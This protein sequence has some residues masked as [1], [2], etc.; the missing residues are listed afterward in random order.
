MTIIKYHWLNRT[1]SAL[2]LSLVLLTGGVALAQ[3]TRSAILGTVKDAT[4]AVV[5]GATVD[6]T[7]TDTNATAKLSTNSSGYFE[8]PYLLPGVY[9]I[10]VTAQGFKRYVQQGY[11]LS[12][13]SRQN[14][15]I[16]L[17]IGST[18]ESVTVTATAA[19]LETTSGSGTS[20]LEGRQISDLPV[21]GN[22]AMLLARSAPGM[23]WTAQPNY[24]SLHSNVGASSV[25]AAGG[26]G[27]SEFSLDGVPS[28][29]GG[30][31]T[32]YLPYTDTVAEFKVETAP[33]DASKGHT[34]S[35]T[36]SLSTKSGTND[37][38]GQLTW[39]HWQQRLNATQSTTNA[40]YW[41]RI[42]QAEAA[43]NTALAEQLKSQSPQPTGRSNNWAASAG[44]PVRAP[45]LY[46]GKDKLFFFFSYNGF[47]D[48]KTE[49]AT[50]VNRTVPSDAH[51]RGDFSDLLKIDPVRYQIYD[52]R[53][54]HC[55]DN[56]PGPCNR[57]GV[58][59]VRNPFPN[60]Q[61][62]ILNPMYK[63]YEALYPRANNVPGVVS[64][65][66]FNN[67]LA[68][69]TPFNWDYKAFTN[70]IDL[71]LTSKQR[72]FGK[73]SY[74]NFSPEN[75]GDWVYET[76]PGLL[77]NGLVRK[78]VGVT[79]DHVYTFNS[80]TIFNWSVAWNRFIEGSASNAVQT[81]F[82]PSAV[83]LPG[84]LDQKAG[85]FIHLPNLDFSAGS[86]SDFTR[87]YP[88][89]GRFS[90]GTVRG[91]LSKYIG[92]H[93][94]RFGVDLRENWRA[95]NGPGNSSGSFS[96]NNSFVRR[97]QNTTNAGVIG[98]EWAAFMLGAP[99]G[100]SISTNDDLYL[101]NKFYAGYV[102]DDWKLTSKLTVNLGLRY[103]LEGGFRERFNR[104]LAGFD[105]EAP[106]PI[107]QAAQEAYAKLPA[108]IL[109]LRPASDF[110][111]KG[112]TLYLG[113]DGAP[114]T[115]NN[116]QPAWMPRLG[117]AYQ[118]NE[119]TVLRG[120]WGMFFDT[121]NALNDGLNQTGYN[122]GTS[123]TVTNN[124]GLD[125]T[126]SD[127]RDPSTIFADPFPLRSDGTR[128]NTPLG[129]ALGLMALT[130]RG[131]TYVDR[132]WKRARQHRWRIGLQRQ[133]TNSLVVEIAHLGSF[134][135]NIAVFGTNNV[136]ERLDILPA[137]YFATG[138]A[139]NNAIANDLN[140]TLPNPFHIDNFASLQTSHPLV[141]ADMQTNGFFTNRN[142]SK[143]QLL[144]LYPQANGLTNGRH[145]GGAQKYRDLEVTLTKRFS[146][147]YSFTVSY[148]WSSNL[149]RLTR[150][151]E[152]DD[153]LVWAPSNNS[154]PHNLNVNFVYEF[155][156]GKGRKWLSNNKWMNALVGGW[157]IGGIYTKQSGR[158]YGLG[159]WFYYGDDLRDIAKDA[160]D[161]TVDAWFNWQL[162]PGAS[163]DFSA[164][165]RTA[166]ETRIRSI[167]PE[168][169]LRQMGNI[170]GSGANQPC[171]YSNVTPVD[172]RPNSFHTRVF[173][174]SLNWLRG[175]GKNQLDANILRRFP[176]TEK[177][178]LEFRLDMINTFNHVL[179][180]NPNT[181]ITSSNFGRVTTQWNTP[182]F[183]QFQLRFAF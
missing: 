112:G 141:Y 19:L 174:T 182:R 6:V 81:S 1:L 75:R 18:Q 157:Q 145:P 102:Q 85:S 12:V 175:H 152:F 114:E 62:P 68:S 136:T 2:S 64:V 154:A 147:G 86:Y 24:L 79:F 71:Q 121:N 101:T 35:A 57:P 21:M 143:A 131:V 138:L 84:Y 170:C 83:G 27:G 14:V 78:N 53:T 10:T 20:S 150:L 179:W 37:Y 82:P 117:F 17:E 54:A 104:G 109:A 5:A 106:L 140:S 153:F 60:N 33:F 137:K 105:L 160:K 41:G 142:I 132:D 34:T 165:N 42:R 26:V 144:R 169:V 180:N 3:E 113:K 77:Q 177:K 45:W 103:E 88:G 178:T 156:F 11:T 173:P 146:R 126:G 111:V 13:N 48:V 58:T 149:D 93:S 80:T 91:E 9:S 56:L 44:G 123:T 168:S 70:R 172:F 74:S 167:V 32:G 16:T 128:F 25:S 23:Q 127:P 87:G 47:K 120:G 39:Q 98:L 97:A 69:A 49:E 110:V 115:V 7:N 43:G 15:D 158:A 55:S 67:Y 46:N 8:A 159:N 125:F 40:G 171:T 130:G 163:R 38:H 176:V 118:I 66:G 92:T 124:N 129:N 36:I 96:Y 133:L 94:L 30:R 50:Q 108:S 76:A 134:T 29:A 22:S 183:I 116:A 61:V 51:R 73:W 119:K 151:N 95:A 181:D 100:V 161:Q 135:D 148:M 155:P 107:A 122:R 31:R 52:P 59:V 162:F 4:G 65:E 72:M 90:V 166:Y 63:F 164:S 28:M 99:S 89:F 139:R